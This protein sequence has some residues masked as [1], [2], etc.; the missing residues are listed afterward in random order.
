M[1]PPL[2]RVPEMLGV[3]E[4]TSQSSVKMI[5]ELVNLEFISSAKT[6]LKVERVDL[7]AVVR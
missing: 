7:G 6:D 1:A 4:A 3:R 2:S 5:R